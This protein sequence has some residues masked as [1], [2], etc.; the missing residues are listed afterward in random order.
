MR[1]G[2][3][4]LWERFEERSLEITRYS[5]KHGKR[6]EQRGLAAAEIYDPVRSVVSAPV[7]DAEI[8]VYDN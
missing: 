8:S 2:G 3:G 1:A 6:A 7:A 4:C 5:H